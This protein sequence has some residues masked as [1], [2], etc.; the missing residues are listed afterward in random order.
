M[1]R[2]LKLSWWCRRYTTPKR[3]IHQSITIKKERK[4]SRWKCNNTERLWV[5]N[6]VWPVKSSGDGA[7]VMI[8]DSHSG[9]RTDEIIILLKTSHHSVKNPLIRHRTRRQ[10][11]THLHNTHTHGQQMNTTFTRHMTWCAAHLLMKR[12]RKRDSVRL[13]K[14]LHQTLNHPSISSRQKP[15]DSL[16]IIRILW[17]HV[18]LHVSTSTLMMLERW[19]INAAPECRWQEREFSRHH[20]PSRNLRSEPYG[21]RCHWCSPW[22]RVSEEHPS[23]S[24]YIQLHHAQDSK[25]DFYRFC[26]V[27]P[28]IKCFCAM[29]I[30]PVFRDTF[31]FGTLKANRF[32]PKPI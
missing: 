8:A 4:V 3:W 10:H 31:I 24:W 32:A 13:L 19:R 21:E 6:K 5:Q 18:R 28:R 29:K 2:L 15:E 1:H 16:Q 23:S 27:N 7:V 11:F 12:E 17:R 30:K 25:I 20:S 9:V 22:R 26:W 14:L